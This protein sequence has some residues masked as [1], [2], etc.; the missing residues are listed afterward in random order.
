MSIWSKNDN[1]IA[2]LML[3]SVLV[4][5]F[6]LLPNGQA[7]EVSVQDRVPTFLKDVVKLDIA[8]YDVRLILGPTIDYPANL[9]GL[10]HT[11]GKYTLTSEK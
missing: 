5:S 11:Y 7:A 6:A 10:A 9:G 4:V 1:A 8:K 2:V 3:A